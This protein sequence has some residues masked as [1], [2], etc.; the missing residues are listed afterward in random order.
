MFNE[1]FN[2]KT[3]KDWYLQFYKNLSEGSNTNFKDKCKHFMFF[4]YY[5]ISQA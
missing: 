1:N 4:H 2:L 5:Y 3:K